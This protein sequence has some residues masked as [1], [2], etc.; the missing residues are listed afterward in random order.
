MMGE[1]DRLAVM[2]P[3]ED[4]TVYDVIAT[5]PLDAGG[6]NATPAWVLPAATPTIVGAPG[7]V[8]GVTLFDG[9]DASPVP[10]EFVAVTV[11]VYAVPLA[12]P[13]T[14]MGE[15]PPLT[16]MPPGEDVTV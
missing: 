8:P 15:A 13:P 5:P 3:G 12:S 6:A 2:P 14:T 16:L 11:N 10:T 7:T 4:V 9:A 1:A